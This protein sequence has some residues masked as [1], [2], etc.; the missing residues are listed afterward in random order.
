MTTKS[1]ETSEAIEPPAATGVCGYDEF[2]INV[3]AILRSELPK[4]FASMQAAPLT[5]VNVAALPER[6]KG[7]YLLLLDDTPVYAGKTDTRH[8][9]RERLKRHAWTVQGRVGLDPHRVAFKAV[10]IMVFSAFDVES[11]LIHELK[12]TNSA[13]L[14]WNNSGFGSNDPGRKREDQEPA[15]FDKWYPVDTNFRVEGLPE[16]RVSLRKLLEILKEKLPYLIRYAPPPA[17]AHISGLPPSSTVR[18]ILQ[19]AVAALPS[20]WQVT[21][22][23][24]RIIIDNDNRE[25]D[26][27][28]EVIR[29]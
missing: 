13:A 12:R 7:A 18:Q 4:F 10:R 1:R 20:G 9:F 11:I 24:G 21:V 8:G 6:S 26:Y 29:S 5:S 28:L 3:E 27:K 25:Y 15:N 14:R 16:G 19:M 2:E 17:D 23:H 22:L